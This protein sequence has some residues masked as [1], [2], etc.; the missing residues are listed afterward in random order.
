MVRCEPHQQV[1]RPA[2]RH[3]GPAAR[4]TCPQRLITGSPMSRRPPC[5][6]PAHG[7]APTERHRATC[8]TRQPRSPSRGG[9]SVPNVSHD[10]V[11]KD[12]G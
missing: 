9:S 2:R 6:T 7:P 1:E 8:H 10:H 3:P 4:P 12:P 11:A 5:G